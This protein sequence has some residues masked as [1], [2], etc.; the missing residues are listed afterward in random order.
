MKHAEFIAGIVLAATVAAATGALAQGSGRA[1]EMSFEELDTDGSGGIS[2]A[3]LEA[4]R[5]ARFAAADG[6]GDGRLTPVELEAAAQARAAEYAARVMERFDANEDGV[7]E[8]AEMPKPRHAGRLF[9]RMDADGDGS[10]SAEEF[11]DARD[12]AQERRGRHGKWRA[13]SN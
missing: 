11:A 8:Q 3:E 4:R 7:L 9:G 1:G 6:D 10:I 13:K 5:T 12:H 2:Q